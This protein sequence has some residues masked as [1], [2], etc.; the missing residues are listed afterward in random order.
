MIELEKVVVRFGDRRILDS[1]SI[2]IGPEPTAVMGPSGSG[3][4]TLLRVL[5]GQLRPHK[6]R[7]L[8]DGLPLRRR[9]G[10]AIAPG[11]ALIHQ[12]YRLVDFLSVID[13]VLLAAEL[14]HHP[15][16]EHDARALLERVGLGRTTLAQLP[17]TLSGGEQQ[18][19][20]IARA[21][22][23]GAK[24]LLADE[25]T[26]A[27]DRDATTQVARLLVEVADT[28]EVQVVVATHDLAVAEMMGS[29]L[30][31]TDGRLRS[32]PIHEARP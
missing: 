18:R 4:T 16:A 17:P 25:P 21:L 2:Q 12:D 14:H 22:L 23:C 8:V 13:N 24:V 20:A 32:P 7:V 3:K 27:L 26:G 19:V 28:H 30:M 9:K 5:A 1:V 15:H 6:G 11:V 31:L 29:R 10:S